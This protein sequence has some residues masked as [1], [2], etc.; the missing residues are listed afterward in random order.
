MTRQDKDIC[1]WFTF[2]LC[3]ALW[4]GVF[5]EPSEIHIAERRLASS[6]VQRGLATVYMTEGDLDL[7]WVYATNSAILFPQGGKE[8]DLLGR[9][10]LRKGNLEW[11][12]RLYLMGTAT[13]RYRKVWRSFNDLGNIYAQQDSSEKAIFCWQTAIRIQP[14]GY[15]APCNYATY[16]MTIGEI[17]KA[18]EILRPVYGS[19]LG[20]H[21]VTLRRGSIFALRGDTASA[22]ACFERAGASAW[23][24]QDSQE[25]TKKYLNY[26]HGGEL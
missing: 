10:H 9:I 6:Y 21:D 26:F 15:L 17:D 19:R 3:Y 24:P 1:L 12:K 20:F 7:A 25:K 16:L 11:A 2:V 18:E 13:A 22:K 5:T 4:V 23:N 8:Y 14:A